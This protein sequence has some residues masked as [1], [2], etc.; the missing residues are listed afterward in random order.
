MHHMDKNSEAYKSREYR[1]MFEAA[2]IGSFAAED[3]VAYSQSVRAY[4]DRQLYFDSA[5]N[6]GYESG[7]T[8]GREEGVRLTARKMFDAGIDTDF[9][10]KITGLTPGQY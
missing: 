2:D 7:E 4:E 1:D 6:D 10:S 9:I 5:Y 3:V 8:K